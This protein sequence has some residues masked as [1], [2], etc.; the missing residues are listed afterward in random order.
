VLGHRL[1]VGRRLLGTLGK[2]VLE[3]LRAEGVLEHLAWLLIEGVR[4][5]DAGIWV[6]IER[7]LLLLLLLLLRHSGLTRT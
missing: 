2:L 3:L 1:L 6:Q 7:I 5:L 4:P